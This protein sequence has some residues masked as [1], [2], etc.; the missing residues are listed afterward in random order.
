VIQ[1]I[2]IVRIQGKI[3]GQDP[4]SNSGL[5]FMAKFRIRKKG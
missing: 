2:F 5:G 3:Q 1:G 4:G